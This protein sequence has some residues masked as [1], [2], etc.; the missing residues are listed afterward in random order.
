M[1]NADQIIFISTALILLS[2]LTNIIAVV[3]KQGGWVAGEF[4]W[5]WGLVFLSVAY[6]GYGSSRWIGLPSLVLANAAFFLAYVCLG[7]Q[8]RFWD[9]KRANIPTW[10]IVASI[11]YIVLFEVFRFALPYIARTSLAHIVIWAL[12]V[13]LLV[14]VTRLYRKTGSAQMLLLAMTFLVESFCAAAR[15]LMLWFAQ[16]SFPD[17][18]NLLAEPFYLIVIRWV[19]LIATAMSY[20]TL[21]T[22]MIEKTL[23]R[24]EELKALLTEKRQLLTAVSK[25]SRNRSASEMASTLVHELAQPLTSLNLVS[26]QLKFDVREKKYKELEPLTD[27]LSTEVERSINI[28]TQIDVLFRAKE[29][30]TRALLISVPIE[31]ALQLLDQRLKVNNITVK[32]EGRFDGVVMAERT[33]L[34]AVFVN[35]I[36]NAITALS[37][38][39]G[40][41]VIEIECGQEADYCMIDIRDS[42]PGIDPVLIQNIGALYISDREQGSGIGLWL[43]TMIINHHNGLLQM[44]NR[45]QGGV[46]ARIRL[47]LHLVG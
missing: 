41:R 42:G 17:P 1:I 32:R 9:S 29:L 36:S 24:N 14:V 35:L 11:G 7:F 21:M 33:Q 8:L 15:L 38:Q 47:P 12:T 30:Q 44:S 46:S 40:Q 6:L 43:S 5:L 10:F 13:Y 16:D 27:F 31:N 3:R 28:I 2:C 4:F 37:N 18:N 20:L 39:S 19:W 23:D 34:E 25:V 45:P 22:F 26:Q